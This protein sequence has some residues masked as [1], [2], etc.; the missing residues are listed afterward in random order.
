M[1]DP[2]TLLVGTTAASLVAGFFAKSAE[3]TGKNA[4]DAAWQ[5]ASEVVH[6]VKE[7]LGS[8]Q[9][10]K[11]EAVEKSP[12]DEVAQ[13][14]LASAI[15]NLAASDAQFRAGL[16]QKLVLAANSGVDSI[17]K[18]NIQGKVEKLVQIQNVYGNVSL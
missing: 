10:N 14:Q 7:R 17:F 2:S 9:E 15:S 11:I 13:N 18:T 4:T 16:S 8:H 12:A 5:R 6:F 3:E 1:L